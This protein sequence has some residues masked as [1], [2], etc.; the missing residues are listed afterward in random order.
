VPTNNSMLG[1]T[2]RASEPFIRQVFIGPARNPSTKLAF[3]RKLYVIRKR[4]YSE[5]RVS[6]RRVREYWY[7]VQ[8]LAA[9]RWSTRACC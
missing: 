8:P 7:V 2:A 3:E 5:I 4:A 1:E 9:R 6:T